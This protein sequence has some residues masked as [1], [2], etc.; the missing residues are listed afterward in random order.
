MA[1]NERVPRI[2]SQQGHCIFRH[3]TKK[4]SGQNMKSGHV[5]SWYLRYRYQ[6]MMTYDVGGG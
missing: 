3:P 1:Y 6:S 4:P 5:K 2:E